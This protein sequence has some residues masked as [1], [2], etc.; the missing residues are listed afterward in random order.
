KVYDAENR[1]SRQARELELKAREV[2][3]RALGTH[4]QMR[5]IDRSVGRI[6]TDTLGV[7]DVEVVA[8]DAAQHAREGARDLVALA[9]AD[10]GQPL[11]ESAGV[12]CARHRLE[13]PAKHFA[14]VSEGRIE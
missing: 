1:V 8:A 13:C 2:R 10:R 11:D 4:Q 3:Q 14:R 6:R 9:R 7:E 5:Q 12:A